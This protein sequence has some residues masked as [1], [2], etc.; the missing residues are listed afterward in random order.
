[1]FTYLPNLKSIS[2]TFE[3]TPPWQKTSP[4]GGVPAGISKTAFA[5]WCSDSTTDHV[6]FTMTEG[7][8]PT[9]RVGRDNPPR[10]VY[11]VVGDYDSD[12]LVHK[13]DAEIVIMIQTA[14]T[15][16]GIHPNQMSRTFQNKIRLI[17]IF[18]K[19][20]P[21]DP[22]EMLKQTI[23]LFKSRAKLEQMMPGLDTTGLEPSH[24]FEQ[25]HSWTDFG[26]PLVSVA[27]MDLCVFSASKKC[28][29][30]ADSV[31]GIPLDVVTI[32]VEARFP[33]RVAAGDLVVGTRVPLFWINDGISRMGGT[34]IEN[35][36]VCYSDRSTKGFMSWR[37][38]FGSIFVKDFEEK[39]VEGVLDRFAY[40]GNRYWV[41]AASGLWHDHPKENMVPRLKKAGFSDAKVK[42]MPLTVLEDTLLTI[43]DQRRVDGS[44]PFL[45]VKDPLV[46]FKGRAF[47]NTSRS[48]AMPPAGTG[49][50]DPSAHW[51][52]IH[53]Y[54]MD[55]L[56]PDPAYPIDPIHYL[57]SWM[58]HFWESALEG[59][60][61]AGQLVVVAGGVDAGKTLFGKHILG[62][63]M[64]GD[65]DATKFVLGTSEFNRDLP[66][67]GVWRIDDSSPPGSA[68]EHSRYSDRIKSLVAN[69]ECPYRAMYKDN[70][71]VPWMG[72]IYLTCNLNADAQGI[73]PKL[74][75][76]MLDKV[77]LFKARDREPGFFPPKYELESTIARELPYFLEWL[78]NDYVNLPEVIP[79]SHRLG[80]IPYHHHAIV[81]TVR[82]M[83]SEQNLADLLDIWS[84]EYV[85]LNP[86]VEEWSGNPTQLLKELGLSQSNWKML[87]ASSIQLGSML[88]KLRETGY[89]R[90]RKWNNGQ[91]A[92]IYTL[93]LGPG[94]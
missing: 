65:E 46:Q 70:V 19:G 58:K 74:S 37:D 56:D 82:E 47:I 31:V 66:G 14:V 88:K 67:C 20:I 13:T 3:A 85:M 69:S 90:I 21:G 42:G 81:T 11:G 40:D 52:F 93:L 24:Y 8:I 6:F 45:Y 5:K 72:R 33:G 49:E 64:G 63:M 73:L 71:T 89:W 51:P 48:V 43:Q 57:L 34:V 77:M 94:W 87:P 2:A 44:A 15:K 23:T 38:I 84:E 86:N 32:E 80:V 79:A 1:M 7:L 26:K 55:F 17:W 68:S 62:P 60:P 91:K 50:T 92:N 16:G 41:K 59:N 53:E 78:K 54:L 10:K 12:S 61:K 39:M 18:E 36:V 27:I 22:D 4:C 75:G 35:G 83:S 28:H 9:I 76:T 29:I 25:G 30:K